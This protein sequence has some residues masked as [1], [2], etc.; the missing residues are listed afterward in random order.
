MKL[1]AAACAFLL[2]ASALGLLPAGANAQVALDAD[3][4]GAPA[5]PS[6]SAIV[7]ETTA[8][9][10]SEADPPGYRAAIEQALTELRL[11]HFSEARATFL[12][13]HE[14]YPNARTLRG[15]GLAEFELRSY[16]ESVQH[17]EASLTHPVRPLDP[18]QRAQT[19][20]FAERARSYVTQLDLS[21]RPEAT[22]RVDGNTVVLGGPILLGEGEHQLE[23]EA[24]GYRSQQRRIR[25]LGGDVQRIAIALEPAPAP[26]ARDDASRPLLRNPWLWAGVGI[27]IAGAVVTSALLTTRDRSSTEPPYGGTSGILVSGI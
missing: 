15:M 1:T 18:A 20:Q 2:S 9:G 7:E 4:A 21:V 27:A 6:A 12:R 14:L 8:T 16:V 17:L 11:G 24:P 13:A 3:S 22:V 25:A 26:N 10:A 5:A 19:Q 23:A